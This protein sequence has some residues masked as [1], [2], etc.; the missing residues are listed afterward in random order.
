MKKFF[1]MLE[2]VWVAAAFAEAG[3]S[4]ALMTVNKPLLRLQKFARLRSERSS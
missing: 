3:V 4:D 1:M 2:D